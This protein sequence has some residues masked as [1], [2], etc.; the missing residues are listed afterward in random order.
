MTRLLAVVAIA[1][2]TAFAPAIQAETLVFRGATI[3]PVSAPVISDGAIVVV[4]G[5]IDAVG[6]SNEIRTPRGATEIDVTGK[7]II[8]G[9]VDAH[10][11]IGGPAGGDR[12]SPLSPDTRSLDAID[13]LSDAFWRARTG[14]IT[15]LNVMPGSGHLMSGQTTYLKVRKSPRRIED[16]LFCD[17]AINGICGGMKMANGTNSIRDSKAFPGTRS[18]SAALQ[19]KLFIDAQNYMAKQDKAKADGKPMPPVDLGLEAVAQILRGERRV[20]FHTHRHNDIMTVLRLA[21]E[22]GFDPVIQHGTDSWKVAEEIAAAGIPVSLTML[23]AP[24]GKEEVLDWNLE[25]ARI[26]DDAGVDVS[27][28]TD[29]SVTDSRLILRHAALAVR[30]GLPETRALEA[31]TIAGA[32][33]LELD[34]RVGSIE[35]GKDAD[36]VILSGEPFSTYTQV[37]Q[38]WVEG[39]MVYDRENPEH[40]K[41]ATGGVDTYRSTTYAHEHDHEEDKR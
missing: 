40:R 26:L 14:G 29:D 31:L 8:P 37:A 33:A 27:I 34:D 39:E 20:Q 24:G 11:H 4:D 35:P 25:V 23:D 28:N 13:V 36:L 41:Y 18:R 15:T 17:D 22:F 9:I 5:R 10:S 3:H 19:R 12:S 7:V 2:S 30:Y 38:T 16:M 6:A 1:F 32:R 21:E